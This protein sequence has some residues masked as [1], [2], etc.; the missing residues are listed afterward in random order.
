MTKI[1]DR[2]NFLQFINVDVDGTIGNYTLPMPSDYKFEWKKTYVSE[3]SRNNSGAITVFPDKFFVP[4]FTVTW[5]IMK[6]DDYS[7]IMKYIRVN[8]LLVR[9]YNPDDQTYENAKFYV[10]QPQYNKLYVMKQEFQFV[11]DLQLIFAGTMN[12]VESVTIKYNSNGGSG[13]ISDQTGLNGD[14][15]VIASGD[16]LSKAGY[17]VK[18][19]NTM[20]DGSG[21]PYAPNSTAVMLRSMELF[22]QWEANS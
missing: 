10:Q 16:G 11:T 1:I 8:E 20:A 22:A 19:W 3:P 4:Y 15:F 18:N 17:Y 5:N 6:A 7:K 9:F 21:T 12:D 14:E 2:T 13:E